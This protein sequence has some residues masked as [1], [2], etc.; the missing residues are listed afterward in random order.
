[1]VS[2]WSF[3][4]VGHKEIERSKM[5][6][7]K[8][9]FFVSHCEIIRAAVFE[10][11]KTGDAHAIAVDR[12]PGHYRHLWPPL[13]MVRRADGNPPDEHAEEQTCKPQG[14]PRSAR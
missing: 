3:F 6:D 11:A 7:E 13:T 8:L 1:G 4:P 14:H 9:S 2:H 10:I 12:C 5:R